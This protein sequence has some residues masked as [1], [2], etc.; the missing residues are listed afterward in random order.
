MSESGWRGGKE[1]V[2]WSDLISALVCVGQVA[3][4]VSGECDKVLL[5]G[6]V[7]VCTVRVCLRMLLDLCALM[8]ASKCVCSPYIVCVQSN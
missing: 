5:S 4:Y 6:F 2:C 8:H 3:T 7:G 1:R